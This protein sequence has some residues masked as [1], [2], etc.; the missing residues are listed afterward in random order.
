MYVDQLPLKIGLKEVPS[1]SN[2][3][4]KANQTLVNYLCRNVLNSNVRS[5]Y[6]WG[7]SG[8]GKTYLLHAACHFVQQKNKKTFY[9]DLND[10][11]QNSLLILDNLENYSLI[12]M[13]GMEVIAGNKAWE[14]KVFHLYNRAIENQAIL[15][16]SS[17]KPRPHLGIKMPDLSSR[18]N[19]GGV[20]QVKALTDD[21]KRQVLAIRA[22]EL[23]LKMADSTIEYILRRCSRDMQELCFLLHKLDR[24]SLST[25]RKLTIPFIK[26]VLF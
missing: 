8:T 6:I 4:G 19:W 2:F 20:F 21:E 11:Q 18:L 17:K 3:F 10:I 16:F 23:G 14:E 26:E 7:N 22:K 24:A 12:C 25:Q 1:F 15:L 9:L 13:D 5:I